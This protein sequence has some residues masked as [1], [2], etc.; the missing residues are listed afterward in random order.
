MSKSI[1]DLQDYI[2]TKNLS[3][4]TEIP[5]ILIKPFIKTYKNKENND[6][7]VTFYFL[8]FKFSLIEHQSN[9]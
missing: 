5:N 4:N 1:I 8:H 2:P 6:Y 9:I 3:E 7:P